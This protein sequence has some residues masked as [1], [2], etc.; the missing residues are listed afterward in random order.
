ME[1]ICKE[2]I[3]FQDQRECLSVLEKLETE[4]DITLNDGR[5]NLTGWFN[6]EGIKWYKNLS[7][8]R[9]GVILVV[10]KLVN[11]ESQGIKVFLGSLK[12]ENCNTEK[13]TYEFE[14]SADTFKLYDCRYFEASEYLLGSTSDLSYSIYDE[15]DNYLRD[16]S[17]PRELQQLL[18]EAIDTLETYV[19]YVNNQKVLINGDYDIDYY[20][21]IFIF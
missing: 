5:K 17:N 11:D 9:D 1:L 10:E 18:K 19:S 14:S 21:Q 7:E 12:K 3:H 13:Y 16:I 8:N 2:I 4:T 15:N 6:D 20:D